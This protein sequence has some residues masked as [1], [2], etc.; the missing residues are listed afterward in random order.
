MPLAVD[1]EG[2]IAGGGGCTALVKAEQ[3]EGKPLSDALL[4]LEAAIIAL[5]REELL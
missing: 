5:T 2:D 3:F 4:G 1:K